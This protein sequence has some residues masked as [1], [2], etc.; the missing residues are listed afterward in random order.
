VTGGNFSC[1]DN[2]PSITNNPFINATIRSSG[3]VVQYN[4]TVSD[5]VGLDTV[6]FEID[7]VNVTPSNNSNIFRF[8]HTCTS[9]NTFDWFRVYANDTINQTSFLSIGLNWICDVT[10]PSYNTKFVNQSRANT[11]DTLLFNISGVT[12]NNV[13]DD[14]FTTITFPN[15]TQQ[16]KTLN[17]VGGDWY[18]ANINVGTT[19]GMLYYNITY[20]NDTAGNLNTAT[21]VLSVNVTAP[22]APPP[23]PAPRKFII[24]NGTTDVVWVDTTGKV[25]FDS[26]DYMYYNTSDNTF[27]FNIG[28]TTVFC[29]NTTGGYNGGNC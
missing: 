4:I 7:S 19:A 14:V 23:P 10:A 28:N 8:N 27:N 5:D 17:S 18:E 21:T 15:G 3:H 26:E 12:D 16:N 1:L 29:I 11:S 13:V 22:A 9:D 20:I 24:R 25:F 2:P 6:F